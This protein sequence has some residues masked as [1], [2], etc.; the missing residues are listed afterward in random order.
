MNRRQSHAP[1]PET[2]ESDRLRRSR[3]PSITPAKAQHSPAL[4]RSLHATNSK[5]DY[6][7]PVIS[8]T[9]QHLSLRARSSPPPSLLTSLLPN[10]SHPR[11]KFFGLVH[12]SQSPASARRFSKSRSRRSLPRHRQMTPSCSMVVSH[13]H[14]RQFQQT[15]VKHR[16]SRARLPENSCRHSIAAHSIFPFQVSPPM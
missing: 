4:L 5:A 14:T 16:C 2:F 3:I 11:E 7:L 8:H 10:A 1:L 12:A 6:I 9:C 13:A 15:R